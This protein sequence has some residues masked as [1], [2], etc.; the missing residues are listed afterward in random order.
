[1]LSYQMWA[2][3]LHFYL[4]VLFGGAIW[5]VMHFFGLLGGR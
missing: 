2:I 3:S 1:M 4:F 5:M